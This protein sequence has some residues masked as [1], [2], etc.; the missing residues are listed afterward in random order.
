MVAKPSLPQGQAL[1]FDLNKKR[2]V[3][4]GFGQMKRAT[5]RG[6]HH[7][8]THDADARDQGHDK[9]EAAGRDEEGRIYHKHCEGLE[10]L[11]EL[12]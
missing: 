10:R 12:G 11:N 6:R 8:D 1:I 7:N 3:V 9:A 2:F 5:L 4:I